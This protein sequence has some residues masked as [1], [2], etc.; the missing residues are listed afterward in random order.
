MKKFGALLLLLLTVFQ[1]NA[2]AYLGYST[3]NYAGA[4][5]NLVNPASFV[6]GRYK[7]D[8]TLPAV[9]LFTYQNFGSFNADAMRAEQGGGGKWWV[10][11]F[12]DTALLNAWAYPSST[13]I[14]RLI[15]HNY[16][17][18]SQGVL[19]ANINFRLDLFN[20]AFHIGEKRSL[21]IYANLRSITNVDNMAPQLA[22]LSEEGL[23]YPA[24]WN[25][26]LNEE[27]VNVDHLTWSEI[28]FNY[29]QVVIDNKTH[30]LKV[31]VTPKILL[32]FASAYVHTNDFSYNLVNEDTSQYLSGTFDYGYSKEVGD[33]IS[34]GVAGLINSN[35]IKNYLKPGSIGFGLD[36]GA[37]YEWRPNYAKFKYDMDGKTDLWMRNENKYKARVG[38]SLL[39]M[40][41][42]K[43]TKGGLSRNFVV[44]SNSLFD[45]QRFNSST[46]LESFDM[47][48]DSLINES[49][50]ANN[51]E[52]VSLQ[53]PGQT[54]RMRTPTAMNLQVDYH[55]WSYFYVNASAMVNMI[56]KKKDSKVNVATQLSF[57]PSFDSPY[58]GLYV[59]IA[60]NKYSGL[61]AG[62]ATRIGPVILGLNDMNIIRA[63]GQISGI[64]FYAGLRLPI[65]YHSVK[66][67]DKD[68]V[69][70]KMD[71]C[72][73]VPGTWAFLGC[74]DTDGDGI[75]DSEDACVDVAGLKEFKGCPDTDG[76]KIIDSEDAC[77]TVA[78]LKEFKGCPDTDGDKIIDSED[79]CPTVAGVAALKGCPD[80]DADGIT[81]AED[82]CP[83]NAGPKENQG[84]PDQ[85]KDGLFDFV[86]NCPTIAGPKENQGCPWPDTDNDGLLDKDDECPN[87]A[88][89][90]A[91]KGCPYKDS[92]NDG[93]L[94]KD[95][96]CPNTPGPKTNKGC[97]VIEQ[98]VIEVL[99]TAFDNL[100]FESNK[101]IIFESSKPSLNE[102]AEVLKK[103]TT[104]K[105]EIS[106][107]TDNVGDDNLNLVLSKKRAEAL[108]AYLMSQGIEE[109][110]LITKYFGE[111]KPIATNDTPE[112]RQKNRRVEMKIVFE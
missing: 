98:A 69:S 97:P 35:N 16:N 48:I 26:Q 19:G 60:Y 51:S 92:D 55:V 24:L 20:L 38:L 80:K 41:G 18:D 88:G 96:D 66:D 63:K 87:L 101:D 75:P 86:D 34:D 12:T 28:G 17:K 27:L 74:P 95:D 29:G 56:P 57:T 107:H 2:Q 54:F 100:E 14:D 45:L 72:K 79:A 47:I 103:K 108:K 78:G 23:E 110:R 9:N 65:L 40:G 32:G 81:D 94:D 76:D 83:E 105:L 58:F 13:F 111:T 106:G 93:L 37:V 46:D 4:L 11:S 67:K 82:A 36:I 7:M 25:M 71:E 6:N 10:Q 102:L 53:D 31:G 44:N 89:P 68:K 30:F 109:A 59:P 50:A 64:D 84:C 104:W 5:G 1:A 62:L 15:V 22:V 91:N 3:S 77:P 61:R 49:T 99:K 112:G 70:D 85:D 43:F 73:N 42:M 90:K 33:F 8:L 52:W 39:D 21:G